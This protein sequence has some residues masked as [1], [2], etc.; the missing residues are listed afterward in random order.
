MV[1]CTPVNGVTVRGLNEGGSSTKLPGPTVDTMVYPARPYGQDQLTRLTFTAGPLKVALGYTQAGKVN[2]GPD[3]DYRVLND[4]P[5]DFTSIREG[6]GERGML[7]TLV[8]NRVTGTAIMTD[9][10]ASLPT[11]AHPSISTWFMTCE[12][13]R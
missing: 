4:A 8:I 5:E 12:P 11:G 9:E 7:Q 1:V 13:Q 3:F 10:E 6:S 2:W